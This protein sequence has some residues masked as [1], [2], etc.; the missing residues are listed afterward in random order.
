MSLKFSWKGEIF[1]PLK[2]YLVNCSLYVKFT[3]FF[4]KFDGKLK[5][6]FVFESLIVKLKF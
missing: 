1:F 2:I 4:W 5:F 3:V 6:M